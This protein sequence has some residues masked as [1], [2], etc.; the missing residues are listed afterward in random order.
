M[1]LFRSRRDILNNNHTQNVPIGNRIKSIRKKLGLTTKEFGNKIIPP[2]SDSLVSRWERGVNRPNNN[3]LKQI[4]ELGN[5]SIDYLLYGV[6]EQQLA[7]EANLFETNYYAS[8]EGLKV[9]VFVDEGN[10]VN[11][12]IW[13]DNEYLNEEDTKALNLMIKGFLYDKKFIN[14]ERK[15]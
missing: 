5:I 13:K 4:A 12:L 14:P 15:H 11:I 3:R 1:I 10:N 6:N 9:P 8:N 2:A 7:K